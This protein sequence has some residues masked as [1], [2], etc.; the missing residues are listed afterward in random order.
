MTDLKHFRHGGKISHMGCE[1]LKNGKDIVLTIE[2]IVFVE[3]GMLNGTRQD[4]WEAIFRPNE[5][6]KLPMALNMTNR[7]RLAKLAGTPFLETVK[8]LTVTLTQEMSKMVDGGKDMA[9]RISNIKPSQA[10]ALPKLTS[11]HPNWEAIKEWL[12]TE[13]NEISGITCKYSV[14]EE[15]MNELKLVKEGKF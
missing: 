12:K 13:G 15:V 10:T 5:Y 7:K 3:Q 9:L 14:E 8:N 4:Y 2:R 11:T 1:A 6:S